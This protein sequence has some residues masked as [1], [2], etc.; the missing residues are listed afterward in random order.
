LR[1]LPALTTRP[2][3]HS[4]VVSFESNIRMNRGLRS[5]PNPVLKLTRRNDSTSDRNISPS[6]DQGG[7]EVTIAMI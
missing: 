6:A 2:S 5:R 3:R 4:K 7:G 1:N